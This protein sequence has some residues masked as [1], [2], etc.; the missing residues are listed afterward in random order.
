MVV[1]ML[2]GNHE[3]SRIV[4]R[5]INKSKDINGFDRGAN[6]ET[7]IMVDFLEVGE[8]VIKSRINKKGLSKSKGK[9]ILLEK[10]SKPVMNILKPTNKMGRS[11]S[12]PRNNPFDDG[13]KMGLIVLRES[14]KT[15][16]FQSVN[17][18]LNRKKAWM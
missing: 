14:L 18:I 15:I 4:G 10:R 9:G 1:D 8:S 12:T 6:L 13:S 3:Y 7:L 11:S 5:A 16:Q 17:P 2:R